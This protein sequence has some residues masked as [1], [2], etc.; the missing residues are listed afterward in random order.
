MGEPTPLRA[1]ELLPSGLLAPELLPPGPKGA[2]KTPKKI[3]KKSL[4]ALDSEGLDQGL[5]SAISHEADDD[6]EPVSPHGPSDIAREIQQLKDATI[7]A[8][9]KRGRLPQPLFWS[10]FHSRIAELKR[11]KAARRVFDELLGGES[12][13]DL[14][15]D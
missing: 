13:G 1:P 5:I 14:D 4:P 15:Q 7:N 6:D 11:E 9:S 2:P 10:L 12:I 3:S 8:A